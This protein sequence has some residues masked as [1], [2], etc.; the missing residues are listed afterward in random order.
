[1]GSDDGTGWVEVDEGG[2]YFSSSLSHRRGGP[3]RLGRGA[4][5]RLGLKSAL[6]GGEGR[7]RSDILGMVLNALRI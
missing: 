7:L 5:S 4:E 3:R 1:M 2:A 6:V